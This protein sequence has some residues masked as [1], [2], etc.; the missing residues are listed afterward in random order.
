MPAAPDSD[1]TSRVDDE[2]VLAVDV[3]PPP[4]QLIRFFPIAGTPTEGF[5]AQARARVRDIVHGRDPR[6]LVI[7]GPCSVHDP[8]AALE[9]AGRLAA[10]RAELA[11]A[12]AGRRSRR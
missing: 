6:L 7:I 1:R 9:Y 10:L 2:R 8:R 5:V 4:E 12:L 11:D 3:L